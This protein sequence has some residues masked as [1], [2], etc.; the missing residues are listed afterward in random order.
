MIRTARSQS[1]SASCNKRKRS[2][3]N[4]ATVDDQRFVPLLGLFHQQWMECTR[5]ELIRIA[6]DSINSNIPES[7]E[8]K[9]AVLQLARNVFVCK[10]CGDPESFYP[11]VLAHDCC[12]LPPPYPP[13]T[14]L[15]DLERRCAWNVSTR[16]ADDFYDNLDK[17]GRS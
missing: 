15:S 9:T 12:T 2:N 7:I 13:R 14:V 1:S 8:Q 5:N 3:S 10:G 11:E 17:G 4:D 6:T 16:N